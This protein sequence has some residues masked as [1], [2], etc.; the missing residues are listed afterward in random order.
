MSKMHWFEA[1]SSCLIIFVGL[2]V[3]AWSQPGAS[4]LDSLVATITESHGTVYKRGFVDWKKAGWTDPEPAKLGDALSEG[5]QIGTKADSWAQVSWP[6]VIARAWEN[7][8]F[9]VAPNKRLVYLCQ[10]EMLLRL[11]KHRKDKNNYYIWTKTMQ[12]RIHGTT[13]L[14]RATP[15]IS[16]ISVLEGSVVLL[17]RINH[18]TINLTP[19]VVFQIN[20]HTG[21]AVFPP[22]N[23]GTA[24]PSTSP[25]I[26]P[27]S[28]SA[29]Q[30]PQGTGHPAGAPAPDQSNT[31][32]P[33]PALPP[34]GKDTG[35]LHLMDIS[36][37]HKPIEL[38]KT[39]AETSSVN[40]VSSEKILSHPLVSKFENKLDSVPLIEDAMSKLPPECRTVGAPIATSNGAST[41]I[42]DHSN[43]S[44]T[45]SAAS[46]QATNSTGDSSHQAASTANAHSLQATGFQ[47]TQ[48][49]TNSKYEIGS[50]ALQQLSLPPGCLREFP[51]SGLIA[52]GTSSAN[53]AIQQNNNST[54]QSLNNIAAQT[55][56][57]YDLNNTA[58]DNLVNSSTAA[59]QALNNVVTQNLAGVAT[60]NIA[61]TANQNLGA[62]NTQNLTGF[63]ALSLNNTL[64]QNL[65]AGLTQTLSGL[66]SVNAVNITS[67]NTATDN[68]INS[69]NSLNSCPNLVTAI[70]SCTLNTNVCVDSSP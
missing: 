4:A 18:S 39:E 53:T 30:A 7:S 46:I 21:Q 11:D 61:S 66:N 2:P 20:N 70:D 60:A 19:G 47:I 22:N 12:A 6:N 50:D 25:A 23:G 58:S 24:Q 40:H 33:S 36:S 26:T 69:V 38:F 43:V 34:S 64:T 35:Q 68:S 48:V 51:P 10:G 1:V 52:A 62:M 63:A 67:V 16:E 45:S 56:G 28:Q 32:S 15:E 31:A 5:M 29:P 3:Q 8:V 42:A 27:S 57:K 49:P 44:N 14:V 41:S 37:V 59:T 65:S 17:N 54:G 9:A 13:V 55:L